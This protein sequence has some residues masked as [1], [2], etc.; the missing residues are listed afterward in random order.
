MIQSVRSHSQSGPG[1]LL[2]RSHYSGSCGRSIFRGRTRPGS[3]SFFRILHPGKSNGFLNRTESLPA[4][5]G[6]RGKNKVLFDSNTVNWF[7]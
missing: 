5:N 3:L 7:I 1:N 2:Y 6:W 4:L